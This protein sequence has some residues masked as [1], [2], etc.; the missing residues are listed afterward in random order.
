MKAIRLKNFEVNIIRIINYFH[1]FCL[2]LFINCNSILLRITVQYE[3][4][5]LACVFHLVQNRE[6]FKN[7]VLFSSTIE[8][9]IIVFCFTFLLPTSSSNMLNISLFAVNYLRSRGLLY[10]T[11]EQC[12]N[13]KFP[14]KT[15][16]NFIY[17][18]SS[19]LSL[20]ANY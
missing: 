17:I 14:T 19:S 1:F 20:H 18:S 2:F 13:F 11:F 3:V 10:S 7:S 6:L 12:K 4:Y 15:K 5:R 9:L 8:S 16:I